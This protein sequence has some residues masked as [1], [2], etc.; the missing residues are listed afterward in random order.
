VRELIEQRPGL[1]DALLR[2]AQA[3]LLA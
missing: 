3:R 2:A 1:R